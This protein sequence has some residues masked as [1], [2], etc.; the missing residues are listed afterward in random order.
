MKKLALKLDDLEVE[1]F[2]VKDAR[3][4]VE[5]RSDT[6]PYCGGSNSLDYATQCDCSAG[7][8]CTLPCVEYSQ[9]T[10]WQACCG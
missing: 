8:H 2:A 9:A 4:G 1:S 5:S 10:D 3:G 7:P 6:L